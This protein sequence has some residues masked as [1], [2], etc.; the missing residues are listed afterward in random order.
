MEGK[1][2][3]MRYASTQIRKSTIVSEAARAMLADPATTDVEAAVLAELLALPIDSLA[4]FYDAIQHATE[5][6]RKA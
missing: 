3:A 5:V 1:E 4:V 6:S 2:P